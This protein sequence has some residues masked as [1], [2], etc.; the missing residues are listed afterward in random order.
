MDINMG[1]VDTVDYFRRKKGKEH[2]LKNHLLAT[3]LTIWV[4][5]TH[6]T[7]LHMYPLYLKQKLKFYFIF[8][9]KDNWSIQDFFL[10]EECHNIQ[11]DNFMYTHMLSL[12]FPFFHTFLLF[13]S[14]NGS[15]L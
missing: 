10:P 9:K 4:Q 14:L 15:L 7:N 12:L 13:S 3:M 8:N 11:Q 5:H 1:G 6:V 2:S